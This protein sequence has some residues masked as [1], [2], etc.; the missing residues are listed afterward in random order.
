M[1]QGA[2]LEIPVTDGPVVS[3][4][5][6]MG[7]LTFDGP[8]A[9]AFLHGQLSTDVLAMAVGSVAWTSY[10]SPKG[11]M[12]ASLLLWH[13]AGGELVAFA[14]A[15][16]VEALRK[17]LT[18]F[19]LRTKVAV[20]DRTPD[21]A[22]F[23]VAGPGARAALETAFGI[24]PERGHGVTSDDVDIVATPDG[25]FIVRTSVALAETVHTR[26]ALKDAPADY[27]NWLGIR[28]GVPT[29][30]RATQDLFVPQTTNFDLIGGIHFRKGCYPGQEIVARMQYL[31]RLKERLFAFHV[32]AAPPAPATPIFAEASESPAGTVVNAASAPTS[33][34]DLLA[35]ASWAAVEA[36]DLRLGARD[37][38]R[39]VAH[40][41]PYAVPPPEAPTRVKL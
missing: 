41:L 5:A 11:R 30:T 36:G 29:I 15:D 12:L 40:A 17:R 6:H 4:L 16:L 34:S 7:L 23:G 18:M 25:R 24:A 14:A 20:S 10:N 8:D 31:G 1:S 19:V 22:L 2:S 21:S 38:P 32:E 35:V 27:W 9:A 39:L 33:G 3:R 13:R 26:L 37:G 28:A